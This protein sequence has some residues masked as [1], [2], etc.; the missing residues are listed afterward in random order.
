[1]LGHKAS[2]S[3]FERTGIVQI[4]FSDHSDVTFLD[5]SDRR[6]FEELDKCVKNFKHNHKEAMCQRRNDRGN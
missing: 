4:V 2:A 3:A 6:R 5:I 1:M